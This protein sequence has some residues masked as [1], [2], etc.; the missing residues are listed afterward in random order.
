MT[1][2]I[3]LKAVNPLRVAAIR[4]KVA[5]Y[6]SVG[7]L[8]ME[9]Y[10]E[11]AKRGLSPAGASMALYYDEGPVESEVD[12]EA[13]VPVEAEELSDEGRLGIR[14][15]PS[16]EQV[17]SLTRQGPYDD[18]TASYEALMAWIEENGYRIIGPNRE[19]YLRGPEAEIPPE[20][21]LTEIQFPVEKVG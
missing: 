5:D 18:F 6:Q 16:Y 21:F 2:N 10:E 15:L 3:E 17:A 19:I 13:A 4:D 7:P 20:E 8:F 14:D 9:L 12:V 11:L 1:E